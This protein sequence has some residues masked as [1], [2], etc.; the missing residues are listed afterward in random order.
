MTAK[1]IFIARTNVDA[2]VAARYVRIAESRV[3]SYLHY[4]EDGDVSG[5]SDAVAQIAMYLYQEDQARARI[6]ELGGMSSESFSEGGVSVRNE[7]GKTTELVAG[8]EALINQV[9]SGLSR[10]TNNVVRFL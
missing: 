3:R 8:Y 1:Q 9:L 5:F 2:D 10:Y 4:G 6:D 7:Y